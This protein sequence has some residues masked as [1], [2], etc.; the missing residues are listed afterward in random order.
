MPVFALTAAPGGPK[1]QPGDDGAPN[2]T[3]DTDG[4][5]FHQNWSMAML[6]D[7]LSGLASVSRPV[8]DRTGIS[9][10][11]SFHEN[12]LSFPR[13]L[14]S[15]E[16]K[17]EIAARI[18]TPDDSFFSGLQSALG[19]KVQGQKAQIEILVIDNAHKVPT[20]N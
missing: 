20:E 16:T 15:T 13:E 9:G 11:W 12:L 10:T 14:G 7:W 4:G 5:W 19:L 8:F 17:A 6:A 1:M 18:E 2:I 3:R